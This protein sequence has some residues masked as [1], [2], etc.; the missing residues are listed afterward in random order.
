MKNNGRPIRDSVPWNSLCTKDPRWLNNRFLFNTEIW[1]E[2]LKKTPCMHAFVI[3][4]VLILAIFFYYLS[5]K[6]RAMN[7]TFFLQIQLGGQNDPT[8]RMEASKGLF[9][10]TIECTWT[11]FSSS[12]FAKNRILLLYYRWCSCK[13]RPWDFPKTFDGVTTF[14]WSFASLCF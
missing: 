5:I 1:A 6:N 13:R 14:C 8:R 4:Q 3:Y 11:W 2:Q 12:V 7:W 10:D 9:E